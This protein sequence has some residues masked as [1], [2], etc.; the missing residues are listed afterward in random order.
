MGLVKDIVTQQH[1]DL[2]LDDA[3]SPNF[4]N[5]V[6]VTDAVRAQMLDLYNAFLDPDS[7]V[8]VHE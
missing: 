4:L 5:Y 1:I 2:L 8:H 7:D 6:P 3:L